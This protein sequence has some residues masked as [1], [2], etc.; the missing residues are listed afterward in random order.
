MTLC[1]GIPGGKYPLIYADGKVTST[2]GP[3][4]VGEK[5]FIAHGVCW[6]FAGNLAREQHLKYLEIDPYKRGI[7]FQR[8]FQTV[9]V[10]EWKETTDS[11][12]D[13]ELDCSVLA[14][15]GGKMWEM[16]SDY[17]LIEPTL[18]YVCI[19]SGSAYAYGA[20][21]GKHLD[22]NSQ[23]YT[24]QFVDLVPPALC[25]AAKL[26]PG[27]GPPFFKYTVRRGKVHRQVL[28]LSARC[29]LSLEISGK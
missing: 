24:I 10:P 15:A 4:Y 29:E 18:P 7:S 17:A 11:L 16:T 1:I 22:A 13:G 20:L 3:S 2:E 6:A 5:V 9:L 14:I 21:V 19:G 8:W 23:G 27:V 12:Y 28:D 26:D 25:V